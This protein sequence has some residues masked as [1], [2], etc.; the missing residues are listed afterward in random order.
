MIADVV[1]VELDEAYPWTDSLLANTGIARQHPAGCDKCHTRIRVRYAQSIDSAGCREVM[2]GIWISDSAFISDEYGIRLSFPDPS[3]ILIETRQECDEWFMICLQVALL[4]NDLTFVHA[5]AVCKDGEA[6]LL[7]SWGG[8]GKTACVAK[9]VR[10]YGWLLLGDDLVIVGPEGQVLAF[11]KSFVVYPYHR[12]L[13][14]GLFD[15]GMGPIAPAAMNGLLTKAA[16]ALKPI[17]RRA[18]GLLSFARRHNPQSR[19]V[20]PYHIFGESCIGVRARAERV[21][22]LER[23][24]E[25]SEDGVQSVSLEEMAS[26]TASVTTLELFGSRMSSVCA[27]M[28]AGLLDYKDVFLKTYS[29]VT[30]AYSAAGLWELRVPTNVPVQEVPDWLIRRMGASQTRA[31]DSES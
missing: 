30:Q 7:P 11:P 18:P 23:T 6:L 5:A 28:G 4:R 9:L 8:V 31:A 3:T 29:I 16:L 26:R 10:E 19:R 21:V 2:D 24:A 20:S 27:L 15:Q 22:W 14:P 1:C 13:F 12:P 17:L 25:L